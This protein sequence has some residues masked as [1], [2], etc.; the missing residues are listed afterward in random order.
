MNSVNGGSNTGLTSAYAFTLPEMPDG[1]YAT[2]LTN[3]DQ[4][5][6]MSVLRGDTD[7]ARV[8]AALL[9]TAPGTPFIYYGEEIGMTGAKPDELIRTPMQWGAGAN[10]GFT[11]G[12][13]WQP[14]NPDYTQEVNVAA[15]TAD[16]ASLLS[17]YRALIALRASHSALRTGETFVLDAG[18]RGLFASLRVDEAEAILVLVNLTDASITDYALSLDSS[19]LRAGQY[20]LIPLFG[21]GSLSSLSVSEGGR[22]ADFMP[23]AEVPAYTTLILNL[24]PIP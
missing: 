13:P 11:I 6:V 23:L 20:T 18:N 15:Q 14:P 1:D 10:A 24:V 2:F 7:K 12:T 19:P 9:L 5:R 22:V 3:H 17:H 16:P 4:N 8:A 21:D